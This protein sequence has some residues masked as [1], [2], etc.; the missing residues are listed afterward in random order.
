MSYKI[1]ITLDVTVDETKVDIAGSAYQLAVEIEN[2]VESKD[3]VYKAEATV[4][5]KG[6]SK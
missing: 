3:G 4:Q 6:G 1:Q 5:K 2:L